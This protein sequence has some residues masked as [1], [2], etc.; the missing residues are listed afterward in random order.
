MMIDD[1]RCDHRHTREEHPSCFRNY[2]DKWRCQHRHTKEEHPGCY[3][4]YLLIR[5]IMKENQRKVKK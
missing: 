4:R 1:P 5:R 3:R 2:T